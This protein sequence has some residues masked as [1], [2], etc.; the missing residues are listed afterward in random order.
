MPHVDPRPVLV[1]GATGGQGGS[2]ARHAL[3][4][5]MSV[6]A[7]VRDPDSAAA[8]ALSAA[9]AQ[10]VKGSF[11]DKAALAAAM[12]GVRA[13]FSMQQDGAPLTEFE[14]L[15]EAAVAAGV[16]QYVHSTV[17]GVRQQEAA[18][19]DLVDAVKGDY[20][21]TKIAQE[22]L[23]RNAPFRFRTFLRPGLILDNLMLRA[24]FLYPRLATQGD[25][26][27][28][29]PVDQ[30]LSFISYDTIGCVAAEAFT[31]PIRFDG[32]EIELAD[33]YASYA[34][35]AAALEQ[36]SGKRVTV[37]SAPIE[38]AIRLGLLPR[39]AHSHVWLTDIGYPARPEMLK[40]FGIEPLALVDW[41]RQNIAG[42]D[43][44]TAA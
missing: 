16:E 14:T 12:D 4:A 3:G 28:A 27:I 44:G 20:W 41:V 1:T 24:A 18:Q 31:D 7:L 13:I 23:V 36:V 2:A 10:I 26:L 5:G 11:D 32:A 25:F 33:A 35:L 34:D 9:G 42:I 17:S 22:R 15:V 38:D 40:P 30:P 21:P 8:Q 29:M 37:T 6:R 19:G 43:I 39:V